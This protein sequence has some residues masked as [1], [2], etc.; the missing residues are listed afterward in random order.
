METVL[1]KYKYLFRT[2]RPNTLM[3]REVFD[4]KISML[5]KCSKYCKIMQQEPVDEDFIEM[6]TEQIY[7]RIKVINLIQHYID[8]EYIR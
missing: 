1:E 5:Q 8:I 7:A 4:M 6:L 2:P 3:E